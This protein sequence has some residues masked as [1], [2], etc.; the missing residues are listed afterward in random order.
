MA[1]YEVIVG[2]IGT[3]YTGGFIDSA[4]AKF[5]VYKAAI[6]I[7]SRSRRWRTSHADEGWRNL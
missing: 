5:A 3:V 4:R 1:N 2:N 6:H 7:G